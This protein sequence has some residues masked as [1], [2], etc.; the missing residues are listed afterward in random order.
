[1]GDLFKA[2]V[3]AIVFAAVAF[4]I[5]VIVREVAVATGIPEATTPE[6]TTPEATP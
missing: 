2:F 6:A 5:H 3:I 4:T 1:M